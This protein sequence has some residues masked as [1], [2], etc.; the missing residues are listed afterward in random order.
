MKVMMM[1]RLETAEKCREV[2]LSNYGRSPKHN[3]ARDRARHQAAIEKVEAVILS[4]GGV[5]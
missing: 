2:L 4:Q 1:A 3:A 5:L